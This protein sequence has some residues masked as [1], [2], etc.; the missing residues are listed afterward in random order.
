MQRASIGTL[1]S[2]AARTKSWQRD[3][4]LLKSAGAATAALAL[5]PGA[6]L[7]ETGVAANDIKPLAIFQFSKVQGAPQCALRLLGKFRHEN[8]A[9][10]RLRVERRFGEKHDRTRGFPRQPPRHVTKKLAMDRFLFQ[11]ARHQQLD[12]QFPRRRE[13]AVRR[14]ALFIVDCGIGRQFQLG[15]GFGEFA[16]GRRVAFAN[17]DHAQVRSET[18]ADAVRFRQDLVKARRKR[19]RDRDGP[20]GVGF[21]ISGKLERREP[22]ANE[23]CGGATLNFPR[24]PRISA[25]CDAPSTPAVLTR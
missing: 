3:L 8:D 21:N 17:V 7:V 15:D 22:R 11:R 12:V 23:G 20:Y 14:I 16:R 24:P 19:C 18:R 2:P 25:A 13:N 9:A 6:R 10:K 4:L 1:V 5:P